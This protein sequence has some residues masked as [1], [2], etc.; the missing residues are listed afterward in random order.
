M[1]KYETMLILKPELEEDQVKALLDEVSAF[2]AKEGGSVAGID[3][4]GLRRLDYP[5]QRKESGHYAVVSFE[6][7]TGVVKELE[8]IMG[9]KDD[10]LRTK[11]LVQKKG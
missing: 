7:G 11:T 3:V 4:W 2:I 8:R 5:I 6:A 9:I 1:S 10:V